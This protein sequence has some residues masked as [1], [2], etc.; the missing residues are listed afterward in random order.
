M[1]VQCRSY[2]T[3]RYYGPYAPRRHGFL[4]PPAAA[5][6]R[7]RQHAFQPSH[8]AAHAAPAARIALASRSMRSS[9]PTAGAAGQPFAA[10]R[11]SSLRSCA[12]GGG[13]RSTI[14]FQ[15]AGAAPLSDT[16]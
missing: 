14:H 2:G 12:A 15:R 6:P 3:S 16:I 13:S 5:A 1:C 9:R 4:D 8:T 11:H 10:A 7:V